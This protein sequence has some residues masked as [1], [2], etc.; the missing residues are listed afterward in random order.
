LTPDE[1]TLRAHF[2]EGPFR[3]GVEDGRWWL[4]AIDW[5]VV[6]IAV[7]AAHRPNGPDAF[8]LRFDLTNY[9]A[10]GPTSGPWDSITGKP[11]GAERRPK[12]DRVGAAFNPGW[13]GGEA[14]YIP[15]DRVAIAGHDAWPAK[16]RQW[17]WDDK[18]DITLYL[19]LVFEL[20]NDDDY[21][22]V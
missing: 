16:Y 22:G 18:K 1:R 20:L 14:L 11:M 6:F 7:R 13:N 10:A 9:P 4:I 2:E 8:V 12:G 5:P 3:A 19:R 21:T 17:I 15:C